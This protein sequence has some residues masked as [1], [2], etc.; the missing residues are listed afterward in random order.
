LGAS[1]VKELGDT[2]Q[3]LFDAFRVWL[4]CVARP[5]AT[6]NET[7]T[8]V[9]DENHLSAATKIWV[10][11]L[12]IS[13]IISFPLLKLY[14]IEWDNF[15]YHLSSWVTTIIGLVVAAFIFHQILLALKLKSE[16]VRTLVMYSVP[17]AAF[18]PVFSLLTYPTTLTVFAAVQD[19][20]QH[21]NPIG[22]AIVAYIRSYENQSVF[23]S[24]VSGA[25][26]A[27]IGVLG[28]AL[29]ALFAESVSQWYGNDRFK[30]Y[31][32]V[33]ASMLLTAIFQ[34]I[35]VSPMQF[36]AIYAFVE[37]VPD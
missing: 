35:V 6:L 11:S 3:W 18:A 25:T 2:L 31:S 34:L 27:L 26:A 37:K 4:R 13:L 28:I 8:E 12:L 19:F 32:A 1:E 9:T 21:P 33:G 5:V 24:G 23:Y 29:V 30:C 22:D 20:K 17:V 16:F 15:G 10:A 14:G 36:L 7:L